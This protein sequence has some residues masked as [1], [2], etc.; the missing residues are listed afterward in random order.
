MGPYTL[1]NS[2]TPLVRRDFIRLY[3][4]PPLVAWI[5]IDTRKMDE[6]I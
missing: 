2:N 3:T 1:I 6:V 4:K 5:Q